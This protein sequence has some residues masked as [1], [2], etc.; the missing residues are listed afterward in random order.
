[1]AGISASDIVE[2]CTPIDVSTCGAMNPQ[3][4]KLTSVTHRNGADI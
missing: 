4:T 2:N 3:D 1:L